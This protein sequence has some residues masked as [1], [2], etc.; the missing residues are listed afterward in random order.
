MALE[1]GGPGPSLFLDQAEARRA[2][3]NFLMTAPPSPP[4]PFLVFFSFLDST[5]SG[6]VT[7]VSG[8]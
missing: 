1:P 8:F 2:E 7:Q 5:V 6:H 4:T 3:N